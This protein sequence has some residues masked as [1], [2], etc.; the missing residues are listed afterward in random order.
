[1]FHLGYLLSLTLD[2]CLLRHMID[3]DARGSIFVVLDFFVMLIYDLI[4]LS[5]LI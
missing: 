3:A 5:Y 4:I 2:D 1:M